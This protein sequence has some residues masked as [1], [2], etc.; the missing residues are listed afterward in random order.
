MCQQLN[1]KPKIDGDSLKREHDI[2]ARLV[3]MKK[4]EIKQEKMLEACKFL[5]CY[6]YEEDIFFIRGI[7]DYEDLLDEAKQQ[8]NCVASYADRIINHS[9]RIYVMR[10]KAHPNRSL[11]TIELSK[12]G[13][14]IKQKLMAYNKPI[15]NKSITDFIDRWFKEIQK[16]AH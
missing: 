16:R 11:V 5:E 6:N 15:H 10:E 7:K 3:R 4:D 8:H 14:Q 9:T 2:C 13:S 12:D 1:M